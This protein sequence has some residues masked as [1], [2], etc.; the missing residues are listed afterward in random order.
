MIYRF[1]QLSSTNDTAREAKY[2][3]GDAVIAT[4]QSAGRGQRGN[5]WS[6]EAGLNLTFSLVLEPI[7]LPAFHQFALLE[8]VALG[9]ADAVRE[10]GLEPLIKWTNDIYIGDYKIAGLLIE[11]DVCGENLARSIV[12][13]GLN[14]NQLS[15][16]P[17][18]PNPTSLALE[19][20]FK[21]DLNEVFA[22]VYRSIGARYDELEAGG[23]SIHSQYSQLLYKK[24]VPHHYSLPS[25]EKFVGTIR[26]V[27][28]MGE[29][30]VEHPDGT[31]GKYLF[32]EIEFEQQKPA[33]AQH[34]KSL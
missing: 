11:N 12:G 1:D 7:F 9:V 30:S 28:P 17:S 33:Q 14:V 18:L 6:S 29:L 2:T 13:I 3:H 31:V 27:S 8:V 5:V 21:Q 16:D 19:T 23:A 15:F 22:T 26:D 25:G 24:N 10:L 4:R 34:S 20:G 32:K